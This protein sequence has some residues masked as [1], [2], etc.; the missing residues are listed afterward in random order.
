MND[1]FEMPTEIPD[2]PE[3][4]KVNKVIIVIAGTISKQGRDRLADRIERWQ[5]NF[6][7]LNIDKLSDLFSENYPQIFFGGR[8]VTYLEKKIIQ[9]TSS[10]IIF[11][12]SGVSE[13]YIEPNLKKYRR[14][15][16]GLI[17]QNNTTKKDLNEVLFGEKE[18]Y[19]NFLNYLVE[20]KIRKVHLKMNFLSIKPV[21]YT[22]F[23]AH[24]ALILIIFKQVE[25][26][27]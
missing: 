6:T 25:K 17:V 18:T 9:L 7:I 20:D 1:C 23:S 14:D 4:Y 24:G 10:D 26:I 19:S 2:S 27:H 3:R 13:Y 5:P 21:N 11:E 12:D 16:L 22:I 8:N 15:T